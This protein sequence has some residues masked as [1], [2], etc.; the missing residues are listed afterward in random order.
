MNFCS[1]CGKSVS[2]KIPLG[3]NVARFVCDSCEAIH[4]AGAESLEVRLFPLAEI[5]WDHIAFPVV[6]DA[7]K[8][9]VDDSKTGRFQLHLA[10]LSDRP[11]F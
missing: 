8:R 5:P 9:Y 4:E 6:R 2:K 11:P 3:D 1:A 10:S 7:L